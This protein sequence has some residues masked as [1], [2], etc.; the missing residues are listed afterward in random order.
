MSQWWDRR[1][2]GAGVPHHDLPLLLLV[3]P[4]L[5]HLGLLRPVAR[6]LADLVE[7]QIVHVYFY[8]RPGV[9]RDA[10]RAGVDVLPPVSVSVGMSED[11]RISEVIRVVRVRISAG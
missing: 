4:L 5:P 11:G 8:R 9:V 3:P 7:V 2:G 6:V 10:R 1:S